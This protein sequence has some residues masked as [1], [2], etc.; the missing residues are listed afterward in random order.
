MSLDLERTERDYDARLLSRVAKWEGDNAAKAAELRVTTMRHIGMAKLPPAD[1]IRWLI[2]ETAFREAVRK[3][4]KWP[5]VAEW[6][7]GA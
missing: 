4:N 3:H 1:S 7:K 6:I 2:L 5:S